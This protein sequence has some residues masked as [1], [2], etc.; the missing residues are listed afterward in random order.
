MGKG[1]RYMSLN[2]LHRILV[3]TSEL[4]NNAMKYLQRFN[5][6][7]VIEWKHSDPM[8][9][10]ELLKQSN[11]CHGILCTVNDKIDKEII[12]HAVNL[13]TISS[14]SVI[15]DHIDVEACKE[16]H[17]SVGNTPDVTSTTTAE[18][19]IALIFATSRR[20]VEAAT[21][22]QRGE[23][24]RDWHPFSFVGGDISNKKVG[25]IGMGRVGT[26]VSEMLHKGFGCEVMYSGPHRKSNVDGYAKRVTLEQLMSDCDI[27]SIHC[28]HTKSTVNLIGEKEL[29]MMKRTAILINTSGENIVNQGALFKALCTHQIAAAGMDVVDPK[30]CHISEQ[31]LTLPNCTILPHIGDAT[32]ETR[33]QMTVM[34]VENII[35]GVHDEKLPYGYWQEWHDWDKPLETDTDVRIVHAGDASWENY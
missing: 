11:D 29:K 28:P 25:I 32:T 35:A 22:L 5:D 1:W 21:C 3:T 27:I 19:S 31:L 13:K 26:K 10:G 16:F 17:V 15:L 12:E 9:Y 4:P 23:C 18:L 33:K 2:P 8:P 7:E 14:I 34:A 30:T 6:V 20:L 24:A